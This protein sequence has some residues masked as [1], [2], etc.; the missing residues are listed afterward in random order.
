MLETHV[1]TNIN[2][3]DLSGF[4]VDLCIQL[5]LVLWRPAVNEEYVLYI[6]SGLWG[7]SDGIWQTQING[8]LRLTGLSLITIS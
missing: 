7:M 8:L 4:I 5:S 3:Y 1:T 6:L 2:V